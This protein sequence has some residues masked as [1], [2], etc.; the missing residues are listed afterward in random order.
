MVDCWSRILRAVPAAQLLLKSP[1]FAAASFAAAMRTRF[2]GQG[3]D[4]S[5]LILEGASDHPTYL[6]RYGAIDIAL[7]P[8]PY[9]GGTTSFETLWMGV[10]M[11]ALQGDPVSQLGSFGA[12]LLN[13]LG[14]SDLVAASVEDYAAKAVALA[15]DPARLTELRTTLRPRMIL[16]GLTDADRLTR[17][18]EAAFRLMW[19]TWCATQGG[20]GVPASGQKDG[21]PEASTPQAAGGAPPSP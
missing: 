19:R 4:G 17:A 2:A 12:G 15:A 21:G 5:R 16:A 14:L 18:V 10:P 1:N 7:D 20:G 13:T 8:F 11:L 9:N 3:V 6:Q